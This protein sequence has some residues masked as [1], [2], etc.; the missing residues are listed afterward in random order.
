MW[1]VLKQLRF[2]P[3]DF[4]KPLVDFGQLKR[5]PSMDHLR[6]ANR[7]PLALP[8]QVP[9]FPAPDWCCQQTAGSSTRRLR[10]IVQQDTAWK[11][12]GGTAEKVDFKCTPRI[13][14]DSRF[15]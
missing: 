11:L 1:D 15:N 12:P 9:G 14:N 4:S 13:A 7:R 10:T 6:R 8:F 3:F 2:D 5:S